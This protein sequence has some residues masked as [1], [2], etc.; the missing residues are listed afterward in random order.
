[1][2]PM[3]VVREP[4]F[5]RNGAGQRDAA[6]ALTD[7]QTY[8]VI[9]SFAH[10]CVQNGRKWRDGHSVSAQITNAAGLKT[11][12]DE[13]GRFRRVERARAVADHVVADTR[14]TI[15]GV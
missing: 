7:F 13:V 11:A 2:I 9:G 1:M 10:H 8:A 12:D 6:A 15:R 4:G 3:T 14:K 5:R